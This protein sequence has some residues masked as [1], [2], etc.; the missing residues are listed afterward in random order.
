MTINTSKL[1]KWIKTEED[2]NWCNRA[3]R[4][5]SVSETIESIRCIYKCENDNCDSW[6]YL[7]RRNLYGIDYLG[8]FV[9]KYKKYQIENNV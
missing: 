1:P 7:K 8:K 6:K 4:I 9:E 3:A 2:C 5:D